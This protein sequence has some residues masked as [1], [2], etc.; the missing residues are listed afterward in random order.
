M[1]KRTAHRRRS[2]DDSSNVL[3]LTPELVRSAKEIVSIYDRIE[4]EQLLEAEC[5]TVHLRFQSGEMVEAASDIMLEMA[6]GEL[7]LR[8]TIISRIRMAF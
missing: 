5:D 6:A 7:G 3:L 4:W 8:N 1:V 2:S